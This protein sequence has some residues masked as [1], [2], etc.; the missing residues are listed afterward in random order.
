[1]W[2]K[3]PQGKLIDFRGD[4]YA[5]QEL[6]HGS[7]W[8]AGGLLALS[9]RGH[10]LYSYLCNTDLLHAESGFFLSGPLPS[11]IHL[12]C[13][14]SATFK[15]PTADLLSHHVILPLSP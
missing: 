5:V 12:Q 3:F 9:V 4:E 8:E 15:S 2:W 14:A 7:F 13:N 6:L 10:F 11:T 1:M